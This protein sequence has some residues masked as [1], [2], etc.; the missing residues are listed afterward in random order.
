MK[1]KLGLETRPL[2]ISPTK[3]PKAQVMPEMAERQPFR[4]LDQR[5]KVLPRPI[6]NQRLEEQRPPILLQRPPQDQRPQRLQEQS[7]LF[8]P[9]QQSRPLN[10]FYKESTTADVQRPYFQNM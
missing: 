9:N 10:V 8:E 2:R 5:S 4:P 3:A 1:A 7:L 6:L